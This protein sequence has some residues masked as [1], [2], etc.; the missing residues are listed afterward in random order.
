[1]KHIGAGF[2]AGKTRS[3]GSPMPDLNLSNDR[4]E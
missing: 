4:S 2:T 1:M 3:H